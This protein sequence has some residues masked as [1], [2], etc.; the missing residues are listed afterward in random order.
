MPI[1]AHTAQLVV[2]APSGEWARSVVGSLA[3]AEELCTQLGIPYHTGW[4][5]DLRRRAAAF[6]RSP[7]AWAHAPYPERRARSRSGGTAQV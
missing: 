6:R 1:G 5:D 2:V 7:E 4:P 3:E